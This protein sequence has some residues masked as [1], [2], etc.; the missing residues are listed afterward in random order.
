MR[1]YGLS[2]ALK[3]SYSNARVKAM[4]SRLLTNEQMRQIFDAKDESTILSVLMQT[5]Y[6]QDLEEYGGMSIKSQLVDFALS[7]NIARNMEL[8]NRV[9]PKEDKE[10]MR[11]ITGSFEISNIKLAMHAKARNI[12][13]ES[14]SR[15][16][17][18]TGQYGKENIKQLM[19]ENTVEMMIS[20]FMINSP[21]ASMLQETL[22][23]YRRSSNIATAVYAMERAYYNMLASLSVE[24]AKHDANVAQVI[25]HSIDMHN[26]ILAF[27]AKE[28]SIK[29]EEMS[30]VFANGG[31]IAQAKLLDAYNSAAN[32]ENLINSTNLFE[33]GKA[34]DIYKN[35][36]QMLAFE[37]S[38]RR[39]LF[40]AATTS[41]AHEVFSF[42]SIAYYA[43]VKEMEA[44]SIRSALKNVEYGIDREILELL[45]SG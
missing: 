23:E 10:M 31:S 30:G 43:Y 24:V 41:V 6:R 13:F 29:A 19:Q 27:R 32:L 39:Q 8:L 40:N 1:S 15:Y 33:M 18:G 17:V 12:P 5:D 9:A 21:Y 4:R 14:I 3:Y 36:G 2:S 38:M 42:G 35:T 45:F 25:K 7:N 26:I 37:M 28:R 11:S 20:R 44:L 16:I 34:Y 22:D